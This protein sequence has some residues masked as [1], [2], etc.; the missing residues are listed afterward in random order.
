MFATVPLTSRTILP[1]ELSDNTQNNVVDVANTPNL[2]SHIGALHHR[3]TVLAKPVRDNDTSLGDDPDAT[4]NH[5]PHP[6]N[7][8]Q[9]Y[10]EE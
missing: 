10:M 2:W 8:E 5:F 4:R 6:E 9:T 3:Y 7:P 1:P